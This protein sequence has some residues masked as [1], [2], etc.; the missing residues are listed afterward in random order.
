[1]APWI[2][3]GTSVTPTFGG[4][5]QNSPSQLWR[6]QT[7][8]T[9][10][11]QKKPRIPTRGC[12]QGCDDGDKPEDGVCVSHEDFDGNKKETESRHERQAVLSKGC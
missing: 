9:V 1:M 7:F 12:Q 6:L 11:D 2:L 10:H 8:R 3:R 5:E 4:S